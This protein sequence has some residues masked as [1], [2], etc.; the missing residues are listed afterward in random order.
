MCYHTSVML[1][2]PQHHP[3]RKHRGRG[4]C[5]ISERPG[6]PSGT[7]KTRPTTSLFALFSLFPLLSPIIPLHRRHSPVSPIIPVHTQKHGGGG[8]PWHNPSFHSGNLPCRISSRLHLRCR[9]LEPANGKV[10]HCGLSTVNC[11]FP[12]TPTIPA[13][14]ATAA[15]RVVPAPIF[16]PTLRI[17]VGAP[18]ILPQERPASEG[19]AP[20]K[21]RITGHEPRGHP[22]EL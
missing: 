21:P 5:A 6:T 4:C 7:Q 19:R 1:R 11:R 13:P 2:V 10:L 18:T 14:S 20:H 8:Y 22:L 15:L 9:A 12:L 3:G 16:T 17:H